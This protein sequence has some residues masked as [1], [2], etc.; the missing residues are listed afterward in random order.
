M[1]HLKCTN[2]HAHLRGLCLLRWYVLQVNVIALGLAFLHV[3][4][5]EAKTLSVLPLEMKLNI[6][7][8]CKYT[9]VR[10]PIRVLRKSSLK[11]YEPKKH[12]NRKLK[13]QV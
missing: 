9:S 4:R 5:L 1:R 11:C 6:E 7:K 3:L 12:K 10:I 2:T 13:I 8:K